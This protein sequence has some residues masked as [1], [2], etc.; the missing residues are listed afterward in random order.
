[1]GNQV[2]YHYMQK[3]AYR[4]RR[5]HMGITLCIRAGIAKIF[6]YGYPRLHNEIVRILGVTYTAPFGIITFFWDVGETEALQQCFQ[7]YLS[8][9]LHH[10]H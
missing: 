3:Y 4:D 2:L 6:A 7:V 8:A 10:Q 1:M 5:M 9:G